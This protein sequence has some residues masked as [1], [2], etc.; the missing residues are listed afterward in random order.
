MSLPLDEPSMRELEQKCESREAA[1]SKRTV[2]RLQAQAPGFRETFIINCCIIGLANLARG[3]IEARVSPNTR[4]AA[5][6]PATI[7]VLALAAQGGHV[8][9][10]KLLLDKGANPRLF[11]DHGCTALL[12]ASTEGHEDCVRLLIDAGADAMKTSRVT[13]NTALFEAVIGKQPECARLLLPVSDLGHYSRD[14]ST[15]F[16][17]SVNTAS[18]ECFE[19][20]LPLVDVNV[21]TRAGVGE[22]Y[23]DARTELPR[24]SLGTPSELPRNFLGTPPFRRSCSGEESKCYYFLEYFLS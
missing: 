24:N 4:S 6:Q 13:G 9:I 10:V 2:T 20:L 21:R 7:P 15:A 1:A 12:R 22:G 18:K 14:G 8:R 19:L 23:E 5:S 17:A 3:A 16:H 11:D